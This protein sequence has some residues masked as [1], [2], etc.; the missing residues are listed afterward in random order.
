MERV[1]LDDG[2]PGGAYPGLLQHGQG[3]RRSGDGGDHE[4][5]SAQVH[6]PLVAQVAVGLRPHLSVFGHDYPTPDGTAMRD[7]IHV[8]DLARAMWRRCRRC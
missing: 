6:Q 5:L 4:R 1:Y 3:V 2:A 8:Q 7:Y